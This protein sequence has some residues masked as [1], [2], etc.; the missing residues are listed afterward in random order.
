MIIIFKRY[1]KN[2]NFHNITVRMAVHAKYNI[3]NGRIMKEDVK[4]F[5]TVMLLTPSH[6]VVRFTCRQV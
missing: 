5:V 6:A 4:I 1:E 3:H 2:S